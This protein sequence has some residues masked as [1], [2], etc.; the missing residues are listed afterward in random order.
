MIRT[1][2]RVLAA[3]SEIAHVAQDLTGGDVSV[4]ALTNGVDTERFRPKA[5]KADRSERRPRIVVPRRLFSKNGVE[6]LVRALPGV[7]ARV[8]DVE[9]LV[10][11]DGPE[12][13]ALERLAREL[14]VTDSVRF[15][16]ARPHAEMPRLLASSDLAVIPSLMEAT[17][18]AG[19]EAMACGVPV[20]ASRV[21]GLPEIIDDEVGR[22]VPPGD[23]DAL[24]KAIV[25]LLRSPS[26]DALGKRA[27]ERV[28]S[29]W[30][31]A[32]LVE[33]HVRIYRTVT[34]IPEDSK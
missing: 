21:G 19:L 11:G 24:A 27:R 17:S 1:G 28:V 7:R 20:V 2:D 9:V 18:V 14:G 3:S 8:P 30:S 34:G 25:D 6:F 23:P 33:R 29:R 22:L 13:S 15:L 10:V 4:E 5:G 16:G 12:R 31:N 26:R 32:R